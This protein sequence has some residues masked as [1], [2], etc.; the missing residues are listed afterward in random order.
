MST[1]DASRVLLLRELLASTSWVERTRGFARTMRS[2]THD[3]GGLLLVGTPDEEPWHLAAHLDDESRLTGIG[4]LKPTLVRYQPPADAP[5]HLSVTLQRLEAARR[6]ETVLVVAETQ[7]PEGLLQ[8]AWD[9]R[10]TGATVLALDT[11]DQELESVAHESLIVPGTPSTPTEPSGLVTPDLS[12]ILTFDSVQ[13]LVSVAA[14]EIT[15]P[16]ARRAFR[17][18]LARMLDTVSGPRHLDR[19]A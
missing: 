12:H 14:G 5:P 11:G 10:R 2:S 16:T 18:R 17:D 9:A 8:R 19:D 6:G 1:M 13:H 4:Q 7:A 3:P 15:E